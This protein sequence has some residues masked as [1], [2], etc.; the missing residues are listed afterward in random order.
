MNELLWYHWIL[1]VHFVIVFILFIALFFMSR[2][3]KKKGIN[4]IL[5]SYIFTILAYIFW[6]ITYTVIFIKNSIQKTK[7]IKK[8]QLKNAELHLEVN[9]LTIV[10]RIFEVNPLAISEKYKKLSLVY[11]KLNFITK[12]FTLIKPSKI[13]LRLFYD[14][15]KYIFNNT[16]GLNDLM[17]PITILDEK[18][19]FGMGWTLNPKSLK[20]IIVPSDK[21]GK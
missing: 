12:E 18:V 9:R 14:A 8:L 3:L 13:E 2:N 17:F 4:H 19:L 20:Q 5:S 16:Y 1:I 11:I 7:L 6:E 15:A 10:E 21:I